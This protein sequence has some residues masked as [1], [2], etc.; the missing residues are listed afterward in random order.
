MYNNIIIIIGVLEDFV[1]NSE[2]NKNIYVLNYFFIFRV[3]S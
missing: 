1:R 3:I 2:F